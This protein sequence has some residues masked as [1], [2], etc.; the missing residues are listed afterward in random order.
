MASF[1]NVWDYNNEEYHKMS[2]KYV[3]L[4][5]LKNIA[6]SYEI[7]GLELRHI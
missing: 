6:V 4:I 1:I 5:C 2:A 7:L 3:I